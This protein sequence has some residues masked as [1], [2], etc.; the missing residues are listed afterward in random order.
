M[1]RARRI[2]RERL[3]LAGL[4]TTLPWSGRAEIRASGAQEDVPLSDVLYAGDDAHI[5]VAPAHG[6]VTRLA[7]VAQIVCQVFRGMGFQV[8][9]KPG[10]TEAVVRFLGAG[11]RARSGRT[12][13]RWDGWGKLGLEV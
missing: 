13:G 4:T 8:N 10:K 9:F 7:A 5:V 11:A 3:D 6:L 2:I 12:E 1:A